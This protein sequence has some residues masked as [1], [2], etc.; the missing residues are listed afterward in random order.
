M[1]VPQKT[2]EENLPTLLVSSDDVLLGSLQVHAGNESLSMNVNKDRPPQQ[3]LDEAGAV[4]NTTCPQAL[5]GR[6]VL[7]FALG[8]AAVKCGLCWEVSAGS[9]PQSRTDVSS[10]DERPSRPAMYPLLDGDLDLE[11]SPTLEPW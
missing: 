11:R 1:P 4:L 6:E 5:S 8:E 2:Q 9:E 10:R 3:L 7:K